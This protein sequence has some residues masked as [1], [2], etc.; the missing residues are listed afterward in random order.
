MKFIYKE[1]I[2]VELWLA[3]E[4]ITKKIDIDDTN[5]VALTKF[6]KATLLTV[7]KVLY[8]GLKTLEFKKLLNTTNYLHYGRSKVRNKTAHNMGKGF[9]QL[10]QD[11]EAII[12]TAYPNPVFGGRNSAG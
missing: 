10:V 8:N 5:F 6:L 9:V 3:S 4:Q 12:G 1:I 7:G 11:V 2:P